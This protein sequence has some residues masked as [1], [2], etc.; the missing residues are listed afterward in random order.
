MAGEQPDQ[1][2][3][4]NDGGNKIPETNGLHDALM[5]DAG[6]FRTAQASDN[7]SIP[8]EVTESFNLLRNGDLN[9]FTNYFLNNPNAQDSIKSALTNKGIDLY[10][11]R[12][13]LNDPTR[14]TEIALSTKVNGI[15]PLSRTLVMDGK[16]PPKA[17]LLYPAGSNYEA[18]RSRFLSAGNKIDVNQFTQEIQ[19]HLQPPKTPGRSM[20]G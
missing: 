14:P 3:S 18:L 12:P 1:P 20:F 19:R 9:G 7:T 13:P 10:V 11:Q 16:N 5:A 15:E 17:D 2:I 6:F 4:I 8:K